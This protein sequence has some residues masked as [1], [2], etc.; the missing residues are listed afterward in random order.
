MILSIAYGY[1]KLMQSSDA[2]FFNS[3]ARAWELLFGSLTASLMQNNAAEKKVGLFLRN[4]ITT[5]SLLL[6]FFCVIASSENSG[7]PSLSYYVV[8]LATGAFLWAGNQ[9]TWA[10]KILSIRP[11]AHIGLISFSAYL[12]HQPILAFTRIIWNVEQIYT[13]RYLILIPI[14]AIAHFSWKYIENPFR[15]KRSN[16]YKRWILVTGFCVLF[17]FGV[18]GNLTNGFQKWHSSQVPENLQKTFN[19]KSIELNCIPVEKGLPVGGDFCTFGSPNTPTSVAVFG[20]S[21]SFSIR[22]VFDEIGREH[23]LG[24]AHNGLGGCPPLIGIYVL[25]GNYPPSVCQ[26]LVKEQIAYVKKHSIEDVFL[27][28]RW[29]LYTDGSYRKGSKIYLLSERADGESDQEKSR[30]AFQVGLKSTIDTYRSMGVRVHL[31][32][33]A[34]MQLY[35]PRQIYGRW[36]NQKDSDFEASLQKLSVPFAVHSEHQKFVRTLLLSSYLDL[37]VSLI[38]L[39][40]IYCNENYCS[41]GTPEISFYYDDDH[42]SSY[43]AMKIKAEIIEKLNLK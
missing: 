36:H 35:N 22:A 5:V 21:H 39:D 2:A 26:N 13:F 4:I 29:S 6:I 23:K 37:N 1:A 15:Y 31:L 38:D 14:F 32:T 10:G 27:A 3:I 24:I 40:K 33:Q 41:V 16:N 8:I 19:D 34:P 20:D 17:S 9:Q 43:G 25:N 30:E 28:A 7:F 12:W 11:I 42:L 18:A